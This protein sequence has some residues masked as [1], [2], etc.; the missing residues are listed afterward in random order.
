V[1]DIDK[2][3]QTEQ[4]KTDKKRQKQTH[5]DERRETGIDRNE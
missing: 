4:I 3:R 2:Q 1:A 5:R